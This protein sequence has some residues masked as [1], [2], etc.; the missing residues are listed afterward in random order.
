MQTNVSPLIA[1]LSGGLIVLLLLVLFDYSERQRYRESLHT[2]TIAQLS[3]VRSNLEAS[4]NDNFYL[5][6]GLVAFVE[7]HPN[8]DQITFHKIA[9]NLLRHKN[10]II[11]IG[12]APSN[13]LSF[14]HP[15]QG[16]ERA[17]GLNYEKNKEQWPAVKKTI[18]SG[19]TI[20]A[21][22][23]K[24][25]Q[26]GL[27]FISRT[28]LFVDS[29]KTEATQSYW[30]LASIVID[31]KHLL[32]DAGFFNPNLE[33][34][35]ALKGTDGRGEFG[36]MIEGDK[37]IFQQNPILLSVQL[38]EGTWQLAAIPLGGWEQ[39]PPKLV[40][41]RLGGGITVL[42]LGLVIFL[43]LQNLI[44]AK[45]KIEA[46]RMEAEQATETLQKNENF[47]NAIFDNIP[48]MIF[49]KDAK[50]LHFVRLN[51]AGEELTGYSQSEVVGKNDY[52]FFP[53][54]EASFFTK[55]DQ[56]VLKKKILLDIPEE[57]IETKHKGSRVLHT[58]KIAVLNASNNPEFLLGISEDITTQVQSEQ[59]RQDL[60]KRLNQAKRLES[61][62]MMAGGVAH[63][64]NNILSGITGYPDLILR[65][66]PENSELIKPIQSIQ[67]SGIRAAEIV[68]DLL[69]FTR[70]AA[71]TRKVHNVHQLID[72][73]LSS[74]EYENLRLIYPDVQCLCQFNAP[75]PHLRC[76]SV[77]I[78]K[79]LMNLITNASEAITGSG[80]IHIFTDNQW[81]D[82]HVET[83]EDLS[84]GEYVVIRIQDT[85]PGV[86]ETDLEH[87]FEPFY[88]KKEMGRSGTGLG[89]TVV[90]NTVKDHKGLVLVKSSS[91]GTCFEL[92]FPSYQKD[93]GENF[94]E[95]DEERVHLGDEESIL[96]VDDEPQLRDIA[97]QML[98]ELG[99]NTVSV[100]SGESAMDFV[101]NNSVDLIVIDML[102]GAGMNG[103]QTYAEI[104]ALDP[105]LRAIIV[106]GFSE[107]EDVKETIKMGAYTF[108]KK[109]YSLV[110][111]GA[112]VKKALGS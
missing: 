5:T 39:N 83:G 58:K 7:T 50:N 89:L 27:A 68:A 112:A 18:D 55:M 25:V 38:P 98:D 61:I 3:E 103:R 93:E 95:V 15:I 109:P 67:D 29:T 91:S 99:Y 86:S 90:W 87:L 37:S 10:S 41:L 96:I 46:A 16:N 80:N 19:K 2:L 111:L 79:C 30:G 56:E 44:Q 72:E 106:S 8:L 88:T 9:G 97:C 70:S 28:P 81:I 108:V 53:E 20:V 64:L 94:I 31:K 14:V 71:S 107:D 47:L 104:K 73:Y 92:F 26:G 36:G 74:P 35:L 17:I 49:V 34:S 57:I 101:K 12:L 102:M 52:D 45:N 40:W 110:Q 77:H 54:E 32:K 11:N 65:K 85:G 13:I 59:E 1:S 82:S 22:P 60:E 42:F 4:I 24:L 69:T 6:R 76:S 43:W 78:K 66:L 21:G 48:I 63:D 105:D 23:V 84:K 62:G 75:R 100:S 33:I 51:K